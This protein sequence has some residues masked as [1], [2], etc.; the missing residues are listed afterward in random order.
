M[1]VFL[2]TTLISLN[3]SEKTPSRS[4]RA[5]RPFTVYS[6]DTEANGPHRATCSSP[7]CPVVSSSSSSSSNGSSFASA[8]G[9]G[10]AS[11]MCGK[12]RLG[13]RNGCA[14]VTGMWCQFS[15]G[16]LARAAPPAPIPT[17]FIV[18]LPEVEGQGREGTGA[19]LASCLSCGAWTLPGAAC[20]FCSPDGPNIDVGRDSMWWCDA[21]EGPRCPEGGGTVVVLVIDAALPP[22][23]L[24]ALRK[25]LTSIFASVHEVD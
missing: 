12:G 16:Y 11:A 1:I 8:S 2:V 9:S 24:S 17:G 3:S 21:I 20:A 14:D 5:T 7:H 4:T 19:P 15:H 13:D 25:A 22:A 18:S 10:A 23:T 6:L